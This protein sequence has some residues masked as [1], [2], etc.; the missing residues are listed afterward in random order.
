MNTKGLNVRDLINVGLFG[1]LVAILTFLSGFIGFIPV[2]VPLTQFMVGLVTGSVSMLYS[3][4]IKKAGMLFIQQLIVALLFGLTAHG[5]WII[6]TTIISAILAEIVLK[7]GNYNSVKYARFAFVVAAIGGIGN[8][9]PIFIGRDKYIERMLQ[10]G[11]SQ[12]YIDRMMSVLPQW[13]LVPMTILGMIG[14]FIG[15]TIG[16]SILKKHFVKAG[17]V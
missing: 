2:L 6:F 7:M 12:D 3:T 11:Y 13:A 9:I 17:M 5:I 14:T 15:C 10:T 16:I 8:W 4:R 1:I